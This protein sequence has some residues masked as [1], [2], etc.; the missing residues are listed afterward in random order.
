[1]V[2]W[3]ENPLSPKPKV[4]R[5]IPEAR[6]LELITTIGCGR[7][8]S[9]RFSSTFDNLR[10]LRVGVVETPEAQSLG[11]LDL[12][13]AIDQGEKCGPL[14]PELFGSSPVRKSERYLG[15]SHGNSRSLESQSESPP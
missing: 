13:S 6:S 11:V 15:W 7:S 14:I 12:I 3:S 10:D 8:V 1:V 2:V 4:N 9:H 5:R